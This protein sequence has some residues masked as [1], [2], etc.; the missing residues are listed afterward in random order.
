MTHPTH[1]YKYLEE[2][3]EKYKH[4]SLDK[5][6]ECH[7]YINK[8]EY[9]DFLTVIPKSGRDSH[10]SCTIRSYK[11]SLLNSENSHHIIVV[12]HSEYPDAKNYCRENNIDYVFVPRGGD[13]FNKCLCMNIGSLCHDS[14]YIHFHDIDILIPKEFWPKLRKNMTGH[15]VVQSFSGRKVNY[16]SEMYTH[17]LF[18]GSMSIES[19]ISRKEAWQAGRSG[20]PGGSLV[21]KRELFEK[22]GGFDPYYFQAYSIED[23]FFVDKIEIFSPFRGCENP[24]IEMF[25]MWHQSNEQT[26]PLNIRKNGLKARKYFHTMSN[27]EKIKILSLYK[28]HLNSQKEILDQKERNA[29]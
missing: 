17:M 20:A 3:Y 26:T 15:D 29:N 21:I 16:I 8:K 4:K 19:I 12:E 9:F 5:T 18:N 7:L 22:I 6:R 2:V 27:H 14:K 11:E 10:F 23:Q 28:D 24:P 25:H 13:L 1:N